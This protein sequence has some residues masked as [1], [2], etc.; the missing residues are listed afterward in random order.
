[1]VTTTYFL[2]VEKGKEHFLAG[3]LGYISGIRH[4]AVGNGEM[5]VTVDL[6][7]KK[8]ASLMRKILRNFIHVRAVRH[9]S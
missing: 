7:I 8:D 4:V 6:S 5:T 2:T 9:D 3:V 1:M